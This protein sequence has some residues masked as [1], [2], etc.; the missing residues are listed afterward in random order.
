MNELAELIRREIRKDGVISFHRFMEMALY[1]PGLGYYETHRDIGRSGD[2]YTSVSVGK[3]FGELLGFQF[4]RWLEP[5]EGEV[6]LLEAGAHDGQLARDILDYLR[7]WQPEIVE[8]T[9]LILLE[10]SRIHRQWQAETLASH[11]AK[12]KWHRAE[13]EPFRGIFYCNELLDACPVEK[14]EWDKQNRTWFEWGVG[15]KNGKFEWR[16]MG[17]DCWSC[18][19]SDQLPDGTGMVEAPQASHIWYSVCGALKEGRA[20]AIDYFIEREEYFNPPTPNATLRAYHQHRASDDLLARV[21][22]Q[23]LTASVS[24]YE[25]RAAGLE[26]EKI[27]PQEKF[28]INVFEQTLQHPA[29]FPE[30]TSGRMR[31]F[32]TLT[33]PDHLGRAFK[34]LEKWRR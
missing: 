6:Q 14:Y 1:E 10:P 18:E 32:N 29:Q 4:A 11:E 25:I 20:V 33:H 5:L 26:G 27:S 22:E 31:Q 24:L 15:L 16:R 17:D 2:F 30:W 13:P 34:V 3:L 9:T 8:R 7:D 23:D 21:G 12:V 19:F 28:L